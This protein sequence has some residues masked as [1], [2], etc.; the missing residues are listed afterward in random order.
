MMR[1]TLACALAW[2]LAV[3]FSSAGE[4]EAPRVPVVA[5]APAVDGE[6]G[7]ESWKGA[8]VFKI[9][10]WCDAAR[11]EKGEKPRDAAEARMVTDRENLYVSF[12]CE[13][14]H[15]DGPWLF[16]GIDANLKKRNY[17]VL[18]GDY[19]AL[20]LDLG[21]FGFYNYYFIAVSPKGEIYR[22]FT[23]PHRYDLVL[24][25]AGLPAVQGAAR[26]DKAGKCWT[27]ELKIPIAELLRHPKDG[28]PKTVGADLRRVQWGA[29]R[30][31]QKFAVYWTGMA[32]VE[33][34]AQ[35]LQYDHMATWR[36]LFKTYPA[37]STAYACGDGWTQLALPEGFG[38]ISLEAGTIDSRVI[39][40]QGARLT[41]H[42][43]ARVGWDLS[44]RDKIA[45]EMDAPRM[46]Y[47]D[48][49]RPE[50]PAG[51]PEIVPAEAA[52]KAREPGSFAA[53]PSAKAV[54]GARRIAFKAAAPTDCAVAV[55]DAQGKIVRHLAAGVLGER[56]PE[57]LKKGT[58]EQELEWDGKDDDGKPVPPGAYRASVSLGLKARF[59]LAIELKKEWVDKDKWPEGLDVENLPAP[60]DVSKA[61]PPSHSGYAFGGVNFLG[62]DRAREELYVQNRFVHDGASGKLLREYKPAGPPG[63]PF[64]GRFGN[65]ELAVGPD[66][67]ICMSGSNELWRFDREGKPA[68]FPAVGRCFIPELWGGHANPHRGLAAGPDGSI[69]KLHHYL[70]HSN[71]SHQVTRIG[72]DGRIKAY[73]FIELHCPAAGV[74]VDRRGNVYVGVTVQPAGAMPPGDLAGKLP[75]ELRAKYPRLYGSILKFGPAGGAVRPEPKGELVS[76][77]ARGMEPFTAEGALWARPG[78]SPIL[79]RIADK[80][81][82]PGC[83]CRNG[84]FDLDDFGRLFVPDAVGG[85]VEVLDANANTVIRFGSR[86]RPDAGGTE[87]GWGTQ[88]AVSDQACYVADY[89]RHRV[90]RAKLEYDARET[91][92][93]P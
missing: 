76:P 73:G 48:D 31:Q 62:I 11:R 90:V 28:I 10:G 69:Y 87:L 41:G 4:P 22:S 39:S 13:E 81:G 61:W 42:V 23:W 53:K 46:E 88:V 9:D 29:D 82:G 19:C 36:P 7:D 78:F 15:A 1:I 52:G 34:R 27:A 17:Q 70:T 33:K 65:G 49:L 21:R 75:E 83:A 92:P 58:L 54:D 18:A 45:R 12:R 24:T 93:L 57:P 2:N 84:R 63:A 37:Y 40:G 80:S 55:L 43:A 35:N 8:A 66:G 5:Q 6:L 64:G 51:K 26:I 67:L 25:E 60:P 79:S 86:G 38:P 91:C 77:G 14:P 71:T 72:P 85:R 32:L 50:H 74:K 56:A 20:A 16:D 68:D 44:R 89:L 30:G 59:D 3:A 47:W